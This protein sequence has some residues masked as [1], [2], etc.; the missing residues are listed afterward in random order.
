M[1]DLNVAWLLGCAG[2]VFMMQP[3]FMC[4]ESGLT[5]SKNNI[6][7]AV[8]NLA[9]VGIS[10]VLFWSFGYALMFGASVGGWVGAKDFFLE[11]AHDPQLSAFFFFQAMFCG[12]CTTIVSGAVAERLRFRGY[13][14]LALLI[15]GLVYP[16]FGH[17]AWNGVATGTLSGWLG[18]LG[19]ADFAGSTVVHSVGG[20]V[21]LAALLIIGPRSGRFTA[22]GRSQKIH[23]SN[24]SFSVLG[25]MLL[26][27]GWL[28]FNGGSTFALNDQVPR[29][30]V[31]TFLAG[32]MGMLAAGA[33]G[34]YQRKLPE[35][36]VLINGS[37]AGL[38]SIT[39]GCNA[40]STPHAALIGGMGGVIMLLATYWIERF[41]IDDG[42]DAIALHGVA[43]AWGSLAV[44]LFGDLEILG[45][46][47]S[48]HHQIAVQLFGIGV[49]FVWAFGITYLLLRVIDR[50]SPLRVSL[51]EEEIGL[52]VSEHRAK[53]EVYQLFQV[54]DEQARTQDFSL[55]VPEDPFT[56][57]GKIAR[58]YNQVM[59]SLQD[60][61]TQMADLN[62]NLEQQVSDRTAE[63][64][65][66][67]KE[68]KRLDRLKDQF[69]A[70]TS[71]ELRTP[72]NG[73][74]GLTE[75]MLDGEQLNLQDR[76]NLITI[77]QS[78]RRLSNLVNDILD[79]S[80]LRHQNL[81]V[82]LK[83]I[84]LR[85]IVGMVLT[86][87]ATL[88]GKKNLQLA[89]A[90]PT[91]LPPVSA[92]EN[93]LQ[94]ILYNLVGNAI[95]F[96]D[97]GTVEVSASAHGT[98]EPDRIAICV[99]DTGIG[100]SP[101]K[102]DRIFGEFEQGDGSTAREYG[103]TGLG[104]AVTRNLVQLHGG[105]I[106]VE[107]QEGEGSSF[108]FTLDISRE[109][110][111]DPPPLALQDSRLSATENISLPDAIAHPSPDRTNADGFKIL[112][113]DDEPVNLQV[114][115]NH[116]SP[117]NY[118]I[119]Q[120]TNGVE[121]LEVIENGFDPD[122]MLLDVMMPK[123]TGY[124]VCQRLRE[125]FPANELP[126]LLLTAKNQ[127]TDIVEGLSSGANDYLTK[128]VNKQELLAR[129]KTH[130]SLSNLTAAYSY[131]VPHEF[132][133][134][135]KKD[136]ILDISLGDQVKQT[137]S[138][139]F[140]DI[141]SFTSLSE[142]MTPEDNFKFINAYLSRMEPAILE[143]CGF[144]DK[145]IG[146]AI[147]ALFRGSADDAVAAGISMLHRLQDYNL[148]RIE[149]GYVPIHNG[150]GINTGDVM[151][152]TVGGKNRMD[153]T[154]IGDVVNLASRIE[155][156]TKHYGTSLL[157]SDRTF[158]SLKNHER[159]NFRIIDRV[160][161]KGKSKMVSVFEIFNA[162]PPKLKAGKIATK[163]TFEQ[164]VVSYKLGNVEEARSLF[165]QCLAANPE[166]T[167][168]Q[169]FL[170][171]TE[172]RDISMMRARHA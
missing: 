86:L 23:G 6:N 13:L 126:I 38:V 58:R 65:Q 155:G 72:L 110:S 89:N 77:A 113:V 80:K 165:A 130:L 60:Y 50:I 63:L 149:S 119:A 49:G 156:L 37:I 19:F 111:T 14:I 151:L 75:S 74:I 102:F 16:M 33:L 109:I 122:L 157:I 48:R 161:V 94:Q 79:F 123:M 9:D 39:A 139:L 101:D 22:D 107:S 55:R 116:L 144:I 62:A 64:A 162:D 78:G 146:D 120:A 125:K 163:T 10:I 20:W 45:T 83:P 29:I 31:Q 7:V 12:T 90:V 112:L 70:N 68:L 152:G 5:R 118:D 53:T 133:K 47:L 61:A 160:Q 97:S 170:K 127:V 73:I 27:L 135:L 99:R 140:S 76:Q 42:V 71:H 36:E 138:V 92:D 105:E 132:L 134:C 150:I 141:R 84:P 137:M 143:N 95:K 106:W 8:K 28:G 15:S 51:E 24:L 145:Y 82:Q 96:T 124:E 108:T 88:V 21:S 164:G 131:F 56:E 87:S 93:R 4:L 169:M 44:G 148:Q 114:L 121:A 136:S 40:V 17:W 85:A 57:V 1:L 104:L 129:L 3:G 158:F 66:A 46:G 98:P 2:L 30:L 159:Y 171:R 35:V 154:A 117:E 91:D 52:N 115:M 166:D 34:W 25:A 168:T 18:R 167:A 128:P 32:A 153:G 100:I 69:L 43:G 147:M 103:G 81:E 142:S 11:L 59:E 67:N 41:R 26:W 54:M 172:S